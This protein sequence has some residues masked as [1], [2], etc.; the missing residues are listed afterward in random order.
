MSCK[1][2]ILAVPVI[3]KRLSAWRNR[4]VAYQAKHASSKHSS[5]AHIC[6]VIEQICK[7]TQC[8]DLIGACVDS[9]AVNACDSPHELALGWQHVRHVELSERVLQLSVLACDFFVV[10]MH[11][12][13]H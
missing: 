2:K 7:R 4:S 10:L 1:H 6:R 13:N 5:G 9:A 8:T 12:C 11:L 3:D